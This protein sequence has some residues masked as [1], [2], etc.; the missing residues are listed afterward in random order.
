MQYP[1]LYSLQHCPYAIRA[2]M[3]LLLAKQPVLLRAIVLKNKPT[4]ML[5]VSPTGTVPLLVFDDSSIIDESLDIMI[6]ALEQND[7]NNLLCRDNP[8]IFPEMLALINKYDNEFKTWLEKYKCAKRYHET[9]K[10][11]YRQQ[12]EL[13]IIQ[14]EQRLSNHA[15]IIGSNP[16]LVDYAVLPFIRQFA[17]VDRKWYIESPYPNLQGW[18]QAHLQSPLFSKTMTKY[19]LWTDTHKAFLIGDG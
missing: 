13:F 3:A 5:Q 10:I 16:S 9:S 7:P 12:C 18:L 15:F 2:R 6:W 14:L 8:D 19:P 17:R 11:D 1:I 4:E